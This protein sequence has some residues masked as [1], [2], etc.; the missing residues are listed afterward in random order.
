MPTGYITYYNSSRNYGFIDCP[1][2]N[3]FDIFVCYENFNSGYKHIFASDYV[4]F[5]LKVLL[6]E[7]SL[8]AT[9]IKFIRNSTL[10]Y[11]YQD[12]TNKYTKRGFLKKIDDNYYVKDTETYLFI[13]LRVS[14][15]ETD[16]LNCYENKLNTQ[17]NYQIIVFSNKNKIRAIN[18]DRKFCNEYLIATSGSVCSAKV[19]NKIKGGFNILVEGKIL[20]FIPY[21]ISYMQIADLSDNL[22]IK[23]RC[24][25]KNES[26]D[27]A[28]FEI[29]KAE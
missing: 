22:M 7:N 15:Y 26:A 2:L 20:G 24:I 27:N 5:E 11:L 13:K 21:S 9:D 12:F 28:V 3:H 14:P 17:I 23:V 8:H 6:E 10:N 25:Q 18:T 16:L 29:I 19:L 1:E 4:E